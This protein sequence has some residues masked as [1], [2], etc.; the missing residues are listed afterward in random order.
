MKKILIAL[1]ILVAALIALSYYWQATSAEIDGLEIELMG[2]VSNITGREMAQL[3]L[4]SFKSARGD[5]FT[6]WKL[7][8]ILNLAKAD[9]PEELTLFS[10]DGGSLKLNTAEAQAAYIVTGSKN[11]ETYFRLIIPTDEFGQR[12]LKYITKISITKAG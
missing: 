3:K 8:N 4:D 2:K 5:E 10:K 1:L 9:I 6:G 7:S 11:G 12:W